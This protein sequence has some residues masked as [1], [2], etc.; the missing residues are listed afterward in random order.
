[1]LASHLVLALGWIIYFLLHSLLADAGFKRR[2][3]TWMGP[4]AKYYRLIYSLLALLLLFP[5]VY[6]QIRTP[7]EKIWGPG[8]VTAGAATLLTVTGLV[9]VFACLKKYIVSKEGFRDLFLE[10]MKPRLQV[11]GL[12]RVVRHPLYLST[13]IFLGGIFLFFPYWSSLL[14]YLL[15]VVYVNL[16]IPLEE[17]KLLALYGDEYERYRKEVPGLWPFRRKQGAV[18]RQ[19]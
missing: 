14:T 16:A 18:S 4:R 10:G 8:W 7:S 15:V 19:Q 1:M 9:G 11:S 12:H 17:R 6:L 2:I 3:A 13:F 5:L